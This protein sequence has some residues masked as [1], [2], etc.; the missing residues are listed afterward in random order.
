MG[1]LFLERNKERN[2]PWKT[3]DIKNQWSLLK[4]IKVKLTIYYLK[5]LTG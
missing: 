2:S 3:F 1:I 5:L 4:V